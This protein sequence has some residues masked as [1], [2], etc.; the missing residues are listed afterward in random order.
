MYSKIRNPVNGNLYSIRSHEGRY[1]LENYI[2]QLGGVKIKLR[3]KRTCA[4]YKKHSSPKCEEHDNC[5][6]V[7]R[8]GCVNV[9]I[10]KD[11]TDTDT[12]YNLQKIID[13]VTKIATDV[14]RDV[15]TDVAR[16]VATDVA[17]DVATDVATDV[18]LDAVS[19]LEGGQNV[20]S[21]KNY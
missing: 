8:K 4:N 19:F 16:D 10:S 18:A 6:W 11:N 12:S 13:M 21:N 3:K 17:R 7:P 15:A 5:K 2:N 20:L 14:A 1:I 9:T